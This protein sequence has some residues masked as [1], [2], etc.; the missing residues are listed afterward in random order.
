MVSRIYSNTVVERHKDGDTSVVLVDLGFS[1]F[2][3]MT[4]RWAGINA[5]E[6]GTALGQISLDELNKKLPPQ[7]IVDLITIKT[8]SN[9]DEK[10]KYGRY[11]GAFLYNGENINQWLLTNN[12]AVEYNGQ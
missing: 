4:I 10:D 1:T 6:M 7:S 5:P 12:L 9:V 8:K 3:R 11:L 2:Q